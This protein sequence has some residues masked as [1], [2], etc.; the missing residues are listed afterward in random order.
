MA[1]ALGERRNTSDLLSWRGA[2]EL[3]PVGESLHRAPH[4]V[5]DSVFLTNREGGTDVNLRRVDP[6]PVA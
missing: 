6:D 4:L 2:L 3:E 5:L 1:E